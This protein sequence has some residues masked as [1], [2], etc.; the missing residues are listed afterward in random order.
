MSAAG[1]SL[2]TRRGSLAWC[3]FALVALLGPALATGIGARPAIDWQPALALSE[4]WRLWSAAWVHLSAAHLA[5]N[6]AGALLVAAL[7]AAACLPARATLAWAL[8]WPLTHALLAVRPSIDHYGGLSGVLHAGVAVCAMWLVRTSSG[9]RRAI[10][11]AVMLG[12][13]VKA[14][15][16]APWRAELP[17]SDLLGIATVPLAHAAGVTAGTLAALLWPARR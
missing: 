14:V 4:P 1:R 12:L 16:E 9:R 8:A 3:G 7:G 17:V 10:G 5:V 11:M 2:I 15:I 6:A 13:V